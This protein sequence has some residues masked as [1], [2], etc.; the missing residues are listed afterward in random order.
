MPEEEYE[1]VYEYSPFWPLL[2]LLVG[3]TLWAGYQL[4]AMNTQR[5]SIVAEY[6]QLAP[7]LEPAQTIQKRFYAFCQD[8]YQSS[9]KDQYAAQIVKEAGIRFTPGPG[10]AAGTDA[11][12]SGAAAPAPSTATPAK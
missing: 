12:G 4:Y 7:N 2:I 6:Q 10:A 1:E 5:M 3:L 11:S 8:L 9:A